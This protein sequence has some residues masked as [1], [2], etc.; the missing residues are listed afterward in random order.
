M[1]KHIFNKNINIH[2]TL[3]KQC[4]QNCIFCL[5]TED[6]IKELK[7]NDVIKKIKKYKT[8]NN[9]FVSIDGGEPTIKPY[10]ISFMKYLSKLK[11]QSI[12]LKTNGLRFQDRKFTEQVL[13]ENKNRLKIY[14]SLEGPSSDI[15]DALT[16]T[17]G[18]FNGAIKSIKN[19]KNLGGEII[20]NIVI[21][22]LNY[23]YLKEYID[24]LKKMDIKETIFLFIIPRGRAWAH[25]DLIPSLE[26]VRP[27]IEEAIHYADTQQIFI[28]LTF[29]PFCLFSKSY[30][31]THAVEF[32]INKTISQW[33]KL[34]KERYVSPLC[35]KC[36]FVDKCPKVWHNYQKL[37]PFNFKPILNRNSVCK[38]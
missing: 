2:L 3:T 14:L 16:Q 24:L 19:I 9:I 37:Y 27:Y 8:S 7:F 35:R 32:N 20:T 38:D 22:S 10:F 18:S 12:H 36:I 21:N 15:H 11:I 4:N 17:K 5:I 29:F 26:K 13:K 33:D 31:Y 6:K 34:N 23:K 1:A 30:Y 25:R 28:S